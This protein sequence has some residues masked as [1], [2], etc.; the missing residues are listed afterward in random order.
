[1]NL[2]AFPTHDS[3]IQVNLQGSEKAQI[4]NYYVVQGTEFK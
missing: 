2:Q 4:S 3:N 1:V